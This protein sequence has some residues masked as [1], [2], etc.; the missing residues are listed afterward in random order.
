MGRR[1]LQGLQ[2]GVEGLLGEHVHFIDDI[3]LVLALGR[4]ILDLL[5]QVPDLVDAPV[6][7]AV[8]FQDVQGGAVGDLP[9]HLAGVVGVRGGAGVRS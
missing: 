1:L 9:A 7:G 4:Q 6:G 2:Q 5:P 8:D 3:D